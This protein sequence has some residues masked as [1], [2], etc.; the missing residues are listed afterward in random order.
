[1]INHVTSKVDLP[2]PASPESKRTAA[3]NADVHA[4]RVQSGVDTGGRSK[5]DRAILEQAI[6]KIRDVLQKSDSRLQ[7]EIDPDLQRVVIKVV[8]E[9][10]DEVI[11]QI[12]PKELLEL[13]KNLSRQNGLLFHDHA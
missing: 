2:T 3:S 12:P 10:S 5:P 6:S 9:D 11:R 1:M 7:I 8:K 13:A 4:E